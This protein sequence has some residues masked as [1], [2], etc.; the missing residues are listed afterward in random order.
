MPRFLNA[1]GSVTALPIFALGGE[2]QIAS[3]IDAQVLLRGADERE[4]VLD[5]L[6]EIERT[7]LDFYATLRSLYRQR[8]ADEI[9]DGEPAPV[10]PIP[11]ISIDDFDGGESDQVTLV[12]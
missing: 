3:A 9:R 7:S 11:S 10:I 8:R 2:E 12:N 6:D 1:G 4:R 5:A